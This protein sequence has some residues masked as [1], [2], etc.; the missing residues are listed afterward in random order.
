[1]RPAT[2][3]ATLDLALAVGPKMPI[4]VTRGFSPAL[5]PHRTEEPS[6][7]DAGRIA[8][9]P[10]RGL[11]PRAR[12]ALRPQRGGRGRDRL[13]PPPGR[14]PDLVPR[15]LRCG[16][17]RLSRVHARLSR[18]LARRRGPEDGQRP[19]GRGSRRRLRPLRHPGRLRRRPA[20]LQDDGHLR[21][22]GARARPR[23]RR[24]RIRAPRARGVHRLDPA[25]RERRAHADGPHAAVGGRR[26]GRVRRRAVGGRAPA[27]L[28][29]QGLAQRRDRA[30][31]RVD[32]RHSLPLRPRGTSRARSAR[33][34]TGSARSSASGPACRRSDTVRPTSRSC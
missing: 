22:R 13:G 21:P 29:A 7:P 26:S 1:M 5:L 10:D 32:L 30:G 14:T 9:L 11:A 3:A 19:H 34:S 2:S 12:D 18:G 15:R 24:P 33:P 4:T 16:D 28:P 20:R 23:P 31:A 27:A 6:P 8:R 25:P 17:R